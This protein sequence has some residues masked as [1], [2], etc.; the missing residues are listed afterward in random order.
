M[1]NVLSLSL[2]VFAAACSDATSDPPASGSAPPAPSGTP[3]SNAGAAGGERTFSGL[4]DVPVPPDLAA[5]AT[6]PTAEVHWTVQNGTARLAYNLPKGLVGGSIRVD[7]SGP[8]DPATGK[9]TLIGEA[10]TSECTAS[11]TSVLCTETMRGLLPIDADMEL[12]AAIA[13][14]EYVGPVQHRIDV[15][16]RFIGDPIGIV[17]FELSTGIAGLEHEDEKD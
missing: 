7:F 16:Q 3:E 8:F 9:G 14:E 4:Y 11:T 12:V 5:A 6:Y 17:R 2:L 10:G 1:K 13:R 15:T